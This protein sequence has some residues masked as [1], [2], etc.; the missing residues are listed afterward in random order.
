MSLLAA[1]SSSRR[2]AP[3]GYDIDAAEWFSAVVAAGSSVSD[4]NKTAVS[5]FVE[6]CK[7]DGIWTAMKS[8]QLLCAASSLA[9][10]LVPLKGTAPSG[11]GGFTESNYSTTTGLIA[12]TIYGQ[13]LY[14][15]RAQTADPQDSLHACSY[16]TFVGNGYFMGLTTSVAS[17]GSTSLGS[18]G[19]RCRNSAGIIPTNIAT[20]NNLF[21][22]SRSNSSNFTIRSNN[23]SE[24]ITQNSQASSGGNY[25]FYGYPGNGGSYYANSRMSFY[26]LGESLDLALLDA[27]VKTLMTSLLLT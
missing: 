6:G 18:G 20:V 15:N 17:A 11:G 2:R 3:A 24:I 8:T 19:V 7:S 16:V 22:V 27:R 13:A 21:G 1:I 9:G 10:A 26:S 14:T 5:A 23:I 12:G 25:V 4:N